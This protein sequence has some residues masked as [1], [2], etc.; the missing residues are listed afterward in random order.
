MLGL[1]PLRELTLSAPRGAGAA[2][3]DAF[4]AR[5][6]EVTAVAAL[7]DTI[8]LRAL[9]ALHDLKLAVPGRIAVIGFDDIVYGALTTPSLTTGAV[10]AA[11]HGRR[12]ARLALGLDASDIEPTPGRVL[13]RESA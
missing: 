11:A 6:P 13:E 7:D 1:E 4:L 2:E 5:H 9:A 3:L 10:D 12:A 8:A